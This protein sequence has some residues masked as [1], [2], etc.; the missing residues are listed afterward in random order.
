MEFSTDIKLKTTS[1]TLNL[2][3][4]DNRF[5]YE[6]NLGLALPTK[7]RLTKGYDVAQEHESLVKS[8]DDNGSVAMVKIKTQSNIG[9][10]GAF[11]NDVLTV[12]LTMA[13]EQKDHNEKNKLEQNGYRVYYTLYEICRRLGL[14]EGS[15]G[16]VSEAIEKISSQNLT[17]NNFAYSAHD[18]KALKKDEKTKI[19]LKKGRVTLA[20]GNHNAGEYNSVFYIEFDNFVVKNLY[21]DYVS[22]LSSNKYLSLTTGPCRRIFVFLSSKRKI[23][24]NRF[25]FDLFELTQVLGVFES[26]PG[27]Q[28]DYVGKY[29]PKVSKQLGI[30]SFYIEKER[31]R[32]SWSILIQFFEEQP[33]IEDK[34]DPFYDVLL[35]YYTKEKLEKLNLLEIDICNYRDEFEA[36][37]NKQTD[38]KPFIFQNEEV[39]PSELAIDIALFQVL[40]KGYIITKSFKALVKVILYA[41]IEGQYEIPEGFRYFVYKRVS[42]REKNIEKIILEEEKLKQ[43]ELKEEEQRKLD[44][45]FL[46]FYKNIVVKNKRQMEIY[47]DRSIEILKNEGIQKDNMMYNF[48]LDSKIEYLAKMDFDNGEVMSLAQKGGGLLLN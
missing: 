17:L 7:F 34:R 48:L 18:K 21:N 29:L 47:T 39:N 8:V 36:K 44:S 12:L 13:Y 37:Y 3:P 10:L 31:G 40:K 46:D 26:T 45:A 2:R 25:V 16:N 11:D 1:S 35:R 38:S 30:F 42:L 4:K 6:L 9:P 43:E 22:V 41:M 23:F 19:I 33:Q 15:A 20:D 28:R 14:Q 24:G 5:K 27:R 32:N